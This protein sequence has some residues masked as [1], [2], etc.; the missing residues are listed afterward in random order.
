H[1]AEGGLDPWFRFAAWSLGPDGAIVTILRAG[2]LH[3]ALDGLSGR[4]GAIA[5]LPI[6]PRGD[7][8]A[9]RILIPARK[10]SRALPALLPGFVLHDGPR[11]RPEADAIL[12]G[13]AGL[14]D[15]HPAWPR[16]R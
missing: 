14:S 16:V 11:F 1:V 3:E 5:A 7:T 8:K 10:G 9:L 4:F 12:R 15:V 6:H 13:E 2:S